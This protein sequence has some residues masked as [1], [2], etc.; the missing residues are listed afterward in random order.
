MATRLSEGKERSMNVLA[1]GANPDDIEFLCA[2][3]LAIYAKRGDG[4]AISYL[5]TGD[6]GSREIPPAEMAA[7]RKEE[8]ENAARVIGA[9]VFPLGIPDGEVEVSLALRRRLIEVIRQTK[10]DVLITHHPRDYMS[11]HNN[12][13][14]LVFD[15]SFWAGAASFAG[16][17]GTAPYHE[18]RPPVFYM[19]TLGGIGFVPEEYV[20]ITEVM[21]LKIEMLRQHKSQLEYMKQRDGLDFL[22]YMKTA[23][24][25]RGYQCGVAHAEGF[26]PE[27]TYPSLSTKRVL[28]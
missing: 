14:R 15:A 12:T 4:V 22:D 19:D 11:D 17:P 2:G 10:P 13:S 9:S 7:I 6:K 21:D 23:A 18:V 27:R 25:Y 26:V 8:A 24:K 20:D 28:P 1:V 5:T 3:T 16:D